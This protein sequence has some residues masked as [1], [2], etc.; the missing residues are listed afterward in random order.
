[1][2][3]ASRIQFSDSDSGN[4]KSHLCGELSR[5]FPLMGEGQDRGARKL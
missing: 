1:M 4:L 5:S 2:S 3:D